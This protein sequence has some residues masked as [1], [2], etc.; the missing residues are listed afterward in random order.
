MREV[1]MPN[2]PTV[3]LTAS[4]ASMPALTPAARSHAA[5]ALVRTNQAAVTTANTPPRTNAAP[6]T[7]EPLP[8]VVA[9]NR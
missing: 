5:S 6:T 1:L 2:N 8:Y 7:A 4:A 3:A 9:S